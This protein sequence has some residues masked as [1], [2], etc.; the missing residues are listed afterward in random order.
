MP[1]AVAKLDLATVNAAI[2]RDVH[3][4]DLRIVAVTGDADG[5]VK[6][7]TEDSPTPIVYAD[8]IVPDEAHAGRDAEIAKGDL[9]ITIEHAKTRSAGGIFQ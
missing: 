4:E 1:D 9:G 7:L 3:V 2:A 8:G 6:S 5:L